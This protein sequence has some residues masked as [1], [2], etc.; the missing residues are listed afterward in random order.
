MAMRTWF[1]TGAGRGIGRELTALLLARGDRVA[2]TVRHGDA[3]DDLAERHGELLWRAVLDMRDGPE[4]RATVDRAAAELGR[5]DVVVGNAGYALFGAVEEPSDQQIADVI[6]TNLI[7]TLRLVRAVLP[8]LRAQGGG[9]IIQLSSMGG[10]IA[11]PGLGYYHLSKWGIEGL[12]EAL[13]QEV[14]GFGIDVTLV[15][16]GDTRTG[17]SG[18]GAVMSDPLPAYAAAPSGQLRGYLAGG[19]AGQPNDPAEVARAIADSA[20]RNPAPRRL[21]LGTDAYQLIRT[22][23]GERLY[24]MEEQADIAASVGF[25]D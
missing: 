25:A 2:A 16:P 9:R 3:L 7:G 4:I 14:G 23:L 17:F 24:E 20:D 18:V 13:R 6:E 22:A 1:I 5:L 21:I 8:H 12:F 19:P 11:F 15:E 10:Q